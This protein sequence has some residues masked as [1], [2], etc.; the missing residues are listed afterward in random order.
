MT[1]SLRSELSLLSE[2]SCLQQQGA[3]CDTR[4]VT[5][6][7]HSAAVHWPLL[8]KRGVWWA[9][10]ARHTSCPGHA[11]DTVVLL[12]GVTQLQLQQFVE[13]LYAG[14]TQAQATI[15]PIISN[16]QIYVKD[17][18]KN[19]VDAHIGRQGYCNH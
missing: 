18:I 8:A 3:V 19:D 17:D 4:L 12:Q 13:E 7:G 2:L 16:R 5:D 15:I 1:A 10:L 9:E 11:P 6:S 14:T